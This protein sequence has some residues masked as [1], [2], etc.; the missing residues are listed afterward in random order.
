[1]NTPLTATTPSQSPT[2]QWIL[3]V[4][5]EPSMRML[6]EV[7]LR[8]QGWTVVSADGGNAALELLKVTAQPP[9]VVICDVLMP[10]IDG[11]DL[12]RRMC[13]RIPGLNVI[14]I[15]GRLSDVSWWPTDLREHRFL[16][17]PFEKSQLVGAVREA[18]NT[19]SAG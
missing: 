11:L 12:V 18:L 19:P 9:A 7:I 16:A 5:D 17:K 15:S 1:M 2:G 10:G 14:F 4:D 13:A 6:M 8:G 3:A